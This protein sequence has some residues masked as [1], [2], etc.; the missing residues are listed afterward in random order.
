MFSGCAAVIKLVTV[1][2]QARD[3]FTNLQLCSLYD[4]EKAFKISSLKILFSDMKRRN[5][6][7]VLCL[8]GG[9]GNISMEEFSFENLNNITAVNGLILYNQNLD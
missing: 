3:I 6:C 4:H 1:P 8:G 2:L 9:V 7:D 5:P